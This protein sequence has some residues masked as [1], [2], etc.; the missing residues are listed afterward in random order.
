MDLI[1]LRKGVRVWCW[2]WSRYLWFTGVV[3]HGA[4]EFRDAGDAIIVIAEENLKNLEK[5]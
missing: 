2:W 4:F 1:D 3:R 5:R